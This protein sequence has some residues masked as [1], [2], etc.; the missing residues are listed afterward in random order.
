MSPR[1]IKGVCFDVSGTI[2]QYERVHDAVLR[3]VFASVS[4]V[5]IDEDELRAYH[6]LSYTDRLIHLLAMRG[7]D[8]DAVVARLAEQA[9]DLYQQRHTV[10]HALVPGIRE[11]MQHLRERSVKIAV[12]SS[13][14][15]QTIEEELTQAQLL[16]F[17]QVVVGA[18]DVSARKPHPE[19][20]E[21][22]LSLL[23]VQPTEAI[24]FE[25]SPPGVESAW[26]AGIPVVGVL[27]H[28]SAE[29]LTKTFDT[30]RDYRGLTLDTL[31]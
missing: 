7:I 13:L 20:Y 9:R 1:A 17:V 8:D 28:F 4:N 6:K 23:G 2:V 30:M 10:K 31:I 25:D 15:H 21:R 24:A 11:F 3:E 18:D 29:E 22:A 19:P 12:V 16:P 5:P 26:L 27:A 14:T